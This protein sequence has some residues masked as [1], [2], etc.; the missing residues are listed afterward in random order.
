MLDLGFILR[1]I[2][3]GPMILVL[4]RIMDTVFC[5]EEVRI[6]KEI[7]KDLY[8]EAK[9]TIKTNLIVL[10]TFL[11]LFI[12]PLFVNYNQDEKNIDCMKLLGLILFQNIGYY[13]SHYVMHHRLYSIHSFHH[14]FDRYISSSI[15][16]AVSIEEFLFAYI[17][18]LMIGSCVLYPNET[19]FIL[20]T[21]LIAIFNLTIHTPSFKTQ[22]YPSLLVSPNE[23]LEHHEKKTIHY[24]APIFSIDKILLFLKK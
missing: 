3:F 12:T 21:A 11:Y 23:H 4:G 10:S 24:A 22:Y 14:R 20:A 17:S 8:K 19:T 9:Y 13:C 5:K 7:H 18:P 6:L 1:G 2:L 15:A 16:F